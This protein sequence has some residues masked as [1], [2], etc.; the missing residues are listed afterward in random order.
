MPCV[1][2]PTTSSSFSTTVSVS[3]IF[4]SF[5]VILHYELGTGTQDFINLLSVIPGQ[6]I[7][8]QRLIMLRLTGASGHASAIAFRE[9]LGGEEA[10]YAYCHKLAMEGGRKLAETMGTH[11]M[12]DSD[13][14]TFFMVSLPSGFHQLALTRSLQT[15]VQLPL[16]AEK[17]KGAL[18]SRDV[19][20]K[21]QLVL[22]EKLLFQ[23]NTYAAHYFHN[24][25][26]W[27]RASAQAWIEVRRF[28]LA[29]WVQA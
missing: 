5:L 3:P 10:I 7:E 19:V 18:Y 20:A 22:R 17:T 4:I 8:F 23:R 1:H 28:L 13:A 12:H 16:P 25:R 24:G 11:V 26:W 14:K 27:V 15:D 2:P 21:I 6:S 9:W 29:L